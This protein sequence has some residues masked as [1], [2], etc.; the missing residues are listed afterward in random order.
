MAIK[1]GFYAIPGFPAVICAVDVSIIASEHESVYANRKG[2]HSINIQGI[3]DHERVN[4]QCFNV[5]W[6]TYIF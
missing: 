4:D 5:S 6:N 2:F 1:M 3:C